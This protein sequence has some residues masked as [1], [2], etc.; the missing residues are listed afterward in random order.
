MLHHRYGR[1][2][3]IELV[4]LSSPID[5]LRGSSGEIPLSSG[6]AGREPSTAIHTASPV[7]IH[8]ESEIEG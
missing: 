8:P 4:S 6:T 5:R 7:A 3:A 1:P 2:P